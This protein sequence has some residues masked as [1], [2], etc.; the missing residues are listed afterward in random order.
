MFRCTHTN[1]RELN[2]FYQLKLRIIELI[3]YNTVV[4]CYGKFIRW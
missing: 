2:K 3:K 1:L 4:C